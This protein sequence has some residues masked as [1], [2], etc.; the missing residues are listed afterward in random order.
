MFDG[1]RNTAPHSP[2]VAVTSKSEAGH[3]Q[4][5]TV[6]DAPEYLA[7]GQNLYDQEPFSNV[8]QKLQQSSGLSGEE[9][10]SLFRRTLTECLSATPNVTLKR[11]GWQWNMSE[12]ELVE[13]YIKRNVL[14]AGIVGNYAGVKFPQVAVGKR[15]WLAALIAPEILALLEYPLIGE[16]VVSQT[17]TREVYSR[18]GD[19]LMREGRD[20]HIYQATP[21]KSYP[22]W[23]D[24]L[25]QREKRMLSLE[26]KSLIFSEDSL[27]EAIVEQSGKRPQRRKWEILRAA[28]LVK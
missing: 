23:L 8:I 27:P 3:G 14:D 9:Y 7:F 10:A 17:R 21:T 12:R 19:F 5:R 18:A 25:A 16:Y 11:A 6:L 20:E 15:P 26:I 2:G 24:E 13:D 28:E 22:K 1:P 4:L